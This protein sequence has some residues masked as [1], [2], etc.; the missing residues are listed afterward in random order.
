MLLLV[1]GMSTMNNFTIAFRLSISDGLCCLKNKTTPCSS[2]L[3]LKDYLIPVDK[4]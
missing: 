1:L 3:Q 2:F 4:D